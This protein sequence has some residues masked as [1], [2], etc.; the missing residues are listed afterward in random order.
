MWSP[1]G[2]SVITASVS[3]DGNGAYGSLIEVQTSD[4]SQKPLGS[5]RFSEV[6]RIAWERNGSEFIVAA[7]ERLGA[8]QLWRVSYPSGDARQITN[9]ESKNYLGVSLTAD[10]SVLATV[11]RDAQASVWLADDGDATRARQITEGKYDG[12]HGLAWTPDGRIVYHSLESGN[13]DI[14][15]INADGSGRRQLTVDPGVDERPS[16]SPDGRHIVF[17]SNRLGGFT[18]WRMDAGGGNER[19]LT[20][21]HGDGSPVVTPDGRWVVYSSSTSG[22]PT[23]WKVPVDGGEAAQ[24]T[25]LASMDPVISPD[26][27]L[28][29]FRY[30]DDPNT[31]G[32]LAVLRLSDGALVKAFPPPPDGLAAQPRQW[33]ADGITYGKAS[34]GASNIWSQ[35]L[36]GGP[37]RQLTRFT[38]ER[39]IRYAWSR[40][41]RSLI[42]TQ[43]AIN[44]DVM[45]IRGAR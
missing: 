10:G 13:E 27:T 43:G 41:G 26:G 35:P 4:G 24:V 2:A 31:D 37:P 9:D 15:I 8:N 39:I 17:A 29:A 25:T 42:Y 12:R 22:R 16:V 21:G 6:G 44:N 19:P 33:T 11:Q 7:S 14:W 45:L 5:R 20:H 36:A 34:G 40:D 1:T 30:R 18:I 32:R 23:L 28:V 38:S 3:T